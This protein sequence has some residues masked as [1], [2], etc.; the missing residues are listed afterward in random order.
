MDERSEFDC[1]VSRVVARHGQ[2]EGRRLLV[3]FLS[4]LSTVER[5]ALAARWRTWARPKQLAPP[6]S[7]RR[8]G[9]LTG[10]GFGKTVAVSKHLNEAVE[11]GEASLVC[12]I[13]QDEQSSLDIQVHGP[14]GLIATA[15]PWF[16]PEWEAS[17]L[18][19]VWPNGARAYVR[20]PEVPGKI[21][22]LEYHLTWASELQSWPVATRDEAWS[23]VLLSTRLGRARVI[24]DA[25]PKRRHPILREL[26]SDAEHNPKTYPVVRG[27]THENAANLGDGYVEELERKIG[28]TLK[29]REELLGEMLDETENATAKQDWIDKARRVR[30]ERFARRALGVDPAVS[31]NKGSDQ[32]GIVLGGLGVDGQAYVLANHSGKYTPP[33]WAKVVLDAY[34]DEECD[35]VLVETNRGGELV[36]SNLRAAAHERGLRVVEIGRKERP[37]RT[38]GVVNVKS[39]YS[40]GAKEERAQPVATSYE[41]GRVSHVIGADLSSLEDTLTTWEPGATGAS[42]GTRVS[43]TGGNKSPDDLDALTFVVVELLDLTEDKPDGRKGMAGIQAAQK[44]LS[45]SSG[46]TLSINR[47]LTGAG[48]G[49]GKI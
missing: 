20:T 42:R 31:T 13:A 3:E 44:V 32:T 16:K 39:L 9:F 38:H 43:R 4:S 17:Q 2:S 49:G 26:L 19:L 29:G 37:R 8:W 30:P 15:P 40:Q 46:A 14:S 1:L 41:R 34:R 12:L 7:W 24:W 6:G 47:L 48:T 21:R 22:G 11:R 45:G 27:T 25:T 10:R 5:A 18:Q 23:N 35:V 33:E 36:V 28:G